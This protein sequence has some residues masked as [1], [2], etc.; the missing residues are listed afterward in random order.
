MTTRRATPRKRR[1]IKRESWL[2]SWRHV[3]AYVYLT[4]C[5]FD[6]VA[7]PIVY[8]LFHRKM[9]EMT[10]IGAVKP[11]DPLTQVELVKT[12]NQGDK[13]SPL[14][15]GENGLFHVAFGAILGVAA[16][17]RGNEKVS[18]TKT[19]RSADEYMADEDH[20]DDFESEPEVPI[21]DGLP[22]PSGRM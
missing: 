10:L 11:L 4:I 3:A 20:D 2:R 13:W 12:L 18:R 9:D 19:G 8:E 16:W 1:V 17:T 22:P 5:L 6:F 7:M 21:E 15:L 14:T